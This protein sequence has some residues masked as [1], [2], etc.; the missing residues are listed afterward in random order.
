MLRA[1][2]PLG[3]NQPKAGR[4]LLTHWVLK[5]CVCLAVKVSALWK[6]IYPINQAA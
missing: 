1:R 6:G 5:G 2:D 3:R 4:L